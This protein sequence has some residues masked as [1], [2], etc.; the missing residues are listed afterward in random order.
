MRGARTEHS[1]LRRSTICP[2]RGLASRIWAAATLA[3]LRRTANVTWRL[4]AI[5]RQRPPAALYRIRCSSAGVRQQ[6]SIVLQASWLPPQPGALRCA[7]LLS[8]PKCFS[9]WP[10]WWSRFSYPRAQADDENTNS[11]IQE[12]RDVSHSPM[13]S[14]DALSEAA[15]M[16]STSATGWTAQSGPLS[17]DLEKP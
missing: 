5:G 6:R 12:A 17:G 7:A 1:T 11:S 8:P 16:R 4:Q 9:P 2:F 15:R 3:L 13:R 10:L 14:G